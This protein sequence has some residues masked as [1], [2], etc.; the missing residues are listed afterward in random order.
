MRLTKTDARL[1]VIIV[2]VLVG[3]SI[4]AGFQ[5]MT[6]PEAP[7][8]STESLMPGGGKALWLWLNELGYQV[9]NDFSNGFLIPDEASAFLV[10]QP[11]NTL[12]FQDKEWELI[13]EWIDHGGTLIVAGNNYATHLF[14]QRYG[15]GFRGASEII[16]TQ[17]VYAPFMNSPPMSV[18]V[19]AN[20]YSVLITERSDYVTLA[21]AE[22]GP[23]AVSFNQEQGHVILTTMVY[24]FTNRGLKEAGNPSF[25]LNIIASIDVDGMILFDE[26]H[27]GYRNNQA[28]IRGPVDWLFQAPI[29]R[30]VLF[31]AGIIVI[32]LGLSGRQF[33]PPL[34]VRQEIA[35]RSQLEYISAVANLRRRAGHRQHTL[36]TYHKNIKREFGRRYRLDPDL[37]DEEYIA[38]L[39]VYNP[40]LDT[41][42]LR[43]L[44]SRLK[45][46]DVNETVM[47]QLTAEAAEWLN[48]FQRK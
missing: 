46:E 45:Q 24:P 1:A 6:S 5:Q 12:R 44:L 10:L 2:V 15:F 48:Y 38:R 25:I 4:V 34:P 22:R 7:M 21:A 3:L 18:P 19:T 8:L 40:T 29:G 20:T 47:V 41:A 16:E 28:A 9:E 17:A 26:W 30:A 36:M 39:A 13:D 43:D 23:L 35:R 33:G 14:M 11:L 42:A 27:H 37:D 32:S 31:S